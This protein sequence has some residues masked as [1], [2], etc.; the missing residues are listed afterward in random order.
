MKREIIA[1]ILLCILIAGCIA[2]L[3]VFTKLTDEV[4][5]QLENCSEALKNG[6]TEMAKEKFTESEELWSKYDVFLSVVLDS[7]VTERVSDSFA[8]LSHAM[9]GDST[10]E[11]HELC[12]QLI[13]LLGD[14]VMDQK[15]SPGSIF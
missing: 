11:A 3:R 1:A 8:A 13:E 10:D 2:D 15:P 7:S 5:R 9:V 14:V 4:I 12:L 6:D